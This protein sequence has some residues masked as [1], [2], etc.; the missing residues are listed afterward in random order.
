MNYISFRYRFSWS[1]VQMQNSVRG[2]LYFFEGCTFTKIPFCRMFYIAL[3][4]SVFIISHWR[5]YI[6]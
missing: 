6:K 4:Y 5:V 2:K 1:A 3:S